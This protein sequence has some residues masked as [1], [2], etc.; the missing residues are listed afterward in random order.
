MLAIACEVSASTAGNHA[1]G[2]VGGDA[3]EG[4]DLVAEDFRPGVTALT[5]FKQVPHEPKPRHVRHR[6]HARKRRELRPDRIQGLHAVHGCSEVDR[7]DVAALLGGRNDAHTEGLGEEQH[8]AGLG[9]GVLLELIQRH[10]PR[11]RQAEDGLRTIDAVPAGQRNARLLTNAAAALQNLARDF[12]AELVNG[13]AKNGD[14]HEWFAPHGVDVTDRVGGSD[15]TK[16]VRVVH[17]GHEKIRRAD[18]AGAVSKVHDRRVV[19]GVVAHQQGWM[20]RSRFHA[21][22]HGVEH[23][24]CNLATAARAMRVLRQFDV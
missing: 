10:A 24:R 8:V 7:I 19:L 20:G 6:V 4:L 14:G 18:D 17:N 11:H 9:C 1:L 15:A 3:V 22:E 21:A 13:P 5:H 12:L 16:R 23:R 2:V